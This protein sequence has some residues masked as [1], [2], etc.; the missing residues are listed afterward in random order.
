MLQV[1]KLQRAALKDP[2]KCSVSTK[3]TTVEKLQ[4]YYV[5]MPSKYKVLA[6]SITAQCRTRHDPV[7]K[8]SGEVLSLLRDVCNRVC[9]KAY[10]CVCV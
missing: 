1:Q 5:F 6:D 3:Y 9:N 4:Q 2:V 8:L 7:Q 10:V